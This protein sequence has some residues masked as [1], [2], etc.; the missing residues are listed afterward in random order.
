MALSVCCLG[1]GAGFLGRDSEGWDRRYGNRLYGRATGAA[2]GWRGEKRPGFS[3]N[4]VF[5]RGTLSRR[6]SP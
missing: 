6:P 4:P 5:W 3:Q 1:I 2:V